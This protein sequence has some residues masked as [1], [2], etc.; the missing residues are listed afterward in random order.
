MVSNDES[1][2]ALSVQED[3]VSPTRQSCNRARSGISRMRNLGRATR[4]SR[5]SSRDGPTGS[6]LIDGTWLSHFGVG[7]G[8]GCRSSP[9]PR[10][11]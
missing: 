10:D 5:G 2:P 4:R 8:L 1:R 3:T 11:L 9:V 7:L 6:Q